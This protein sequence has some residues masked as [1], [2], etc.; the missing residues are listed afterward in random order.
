MKNAAISCEGRFDLLAPVSLRSDHIFAVAGTPARSVLI[1]RTTRYP[2]IPWLCLDSLGREVLVFIFPKCSVPPVGKV[3]DL[4]SIRFLSLFQWTAKRRARKP[5][6]IPSTGLR[7]A[8]QNE[9]LRSESVLALDFVVIILLDSL[10]VTSQS[11]Q[12]QSMERVQVKTPGHAQAVV[13]LITHD[14]ATGFRP[15]DAVDFSTVI[16]LSR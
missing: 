12:R 5:I 2:R 14:G 7:T 11:W 10:L 8:N 6:N 1:P 15:G 4:E 16:P 13:A 9:T 3:E